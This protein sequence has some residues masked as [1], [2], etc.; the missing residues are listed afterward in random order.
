MMLLT[1]AGESAIDIFNIFSLTA[2]EK[3]D[4]K[5]VLEKFDSYCSPR[6]NEVYKRYVF[7]CRNQ[8][9]GEQ[10]VIDIRLKCDQ[11]LS[12]RFTGL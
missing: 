1:I 9:E 10:F 8:K 2:A 3:K 4:L 11:E 12:V 6:K 5:V 7:R